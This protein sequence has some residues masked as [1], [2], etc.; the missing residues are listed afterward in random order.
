MP[1]NNSPQK[2]VSTREAA[3]IL[4]VGTSTIVR[5]IHR[6]DLDAHKKTLAP[7]SPFRIYQSSLE[8]VLDQRQH[9]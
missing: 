6:G 8:H 5:M 2:T 1:N 9:N 3:E 7:H 4:N